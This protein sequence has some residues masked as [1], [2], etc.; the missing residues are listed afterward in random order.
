MRVVG[1]TSAKGGGAQWNAPH[2]FNEIWEHDCA[3]Q[4]FFEFDNWQRYFQ[5]AAGHGQEKVMSAECAQFTSFRKLEADLMQTEH[6]AKENVNRV[7]GF[8]A[9]RSAVLPWLRETGIVNHPAGLQ[10]HEIKAATARPFPS[11][12]ES[13]ETDRRMDRECLA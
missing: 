11:E 10:K 9:H 3:Y 4:C 13:V 5:V 2:L 7:R 12:N 6:D 1:Q 8:A